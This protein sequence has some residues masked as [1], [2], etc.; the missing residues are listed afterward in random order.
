MSF[1]TSILFLQHLRVWFGC[2]FIR[3]Y[4]YS[5]YCMT[6]RGEMIKKPAGR[7]FQCKKDNYFLNSLTFEMLRARNHP[8]LILEAECCVK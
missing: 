8:F 1:K 4:I 6:M 7:L 2:P 5:E 3:C